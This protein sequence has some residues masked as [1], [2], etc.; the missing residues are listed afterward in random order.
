MDSGKL[1]SIM[2]EKIW[3]R[4]LKYPSELWAWLWKHKYSPTVNEYNLIR[5]N[6]QIQGSNMW[7][8][9]WKNQPIIQEH[10]FWEIRE[11]QMTLF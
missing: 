6:D 10:T 9:A 11:G 1:K 4:W 2:R 8:A 7:N 3:W 5:F